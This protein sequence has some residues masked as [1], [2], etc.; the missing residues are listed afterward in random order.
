MK[1]ESGKYILYTD[2][3][4]NHW[5]EEQYEFET[6]NKEGNKEIKQ[7]YRRIAGYVSTFAQL[8]KD[9]LK[10]K[11]ASDDSGELETVLENLVQAEK[12]IDELYLKYKAELEGV[13]K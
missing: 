7:G 5:I 13:K 11:F 4:E 6:K 8:S 12:E 2:S 3:N 10:R 1:I 9:F